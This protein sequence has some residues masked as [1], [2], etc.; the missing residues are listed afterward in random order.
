MPVTRWVEGPISIVASDEPDPEALTAWERLVTG[1]PG[2]DVAQLPSWARVR[3]QA[4]FTPLYVLAYHGST[5]VGGAQILQRRLS[6]LGPVGYVP[7]G[8]VV[9]SRP[10][11]AEVCRALSVALEELCRKRFRGLFVQPPEGGDDIG[12][13]LRERGF[14]PSD[15]GIAPI[16]SIR[17]DLGLSETQLRHM[18]SSKLRR[19]TRNG[20]WASQGVQVRLGG[21]QDIPL[22]ARLLAHTAAYQGFE[23]L[24]EDYLRTL[25][26]ELSSA[27]LAVLFVGELDGEPLATQLFTFC[28]DTFKMRIM[29]FERTERAAR[30]HFPSAVVWEA[31]RWAKSRGFRWFDFG[32]LSPAAL[33]VLLDGEGERKDLPGPDEFKVRWGGTPFRYPAPVELLPSLVVRAGYDLARRGLGG[34]RVLHAMRGRLRHGA[35][36]TTPEHAS[37]GAAGAAE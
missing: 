22:L 6:V 27:G 20:K 18:L 26:Q 24:P 32:G 8:P 14:R 15:A 25:Y 2:S 10:D 29:G 16:G 31:L 23:P 12:D 21:E 1:T 7:Y 4:G 17:L 28:S 35:G 37:V 33:S 34:H 3:A 5:L 30:L 13:H 11:R 9:A 19:W 36:R